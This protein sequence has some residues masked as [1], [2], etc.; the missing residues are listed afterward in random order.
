VIT[1]ADVPRGASPARDGRATP[2]AYEGENQ[3]QYILTDKARYI[4]DWIAAVAAVD[5]Y[6]AERALDLIEVEYEVL[7]AVFDPEDALEASAP[8]IH[9]RWK[10]NVAAV[11][12]HPFNRG[13]LD[14]ALAASAH[15]VEFSGRNSRQKQAH[16]EP[17]V[18][19]AAWDESGRLTVWSPNQ[20]AHLAKKAMARRVF[21]IGEGDVR[22]ITPAV[23]GGFGARLSFGVEPVAAM[24]AKVAG[25]PVKVVV[26][27]EEDFSGW[28]SRTEQRQTIRIGVAGT[29]R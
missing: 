22:W 13:D 15:V 19:L 10:D 2:F 14:G 5:V 17:D 21:D 3:D 27:R 24:L 9:Q 1:H 29:A 23:G 6:T 20:N 7:P 25:R 28:N 12:D 26:T 4:G 18:A 16:M 8:V 11:I